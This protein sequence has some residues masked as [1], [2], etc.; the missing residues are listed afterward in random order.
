[1][2]TLDDID[3]FETLEYIKRTAP[4]Y[5]KAKADRIF[6]EEF[7]KS[8][9]ASLMATQVG[10]PVNAQERYAYAHPDYTLHLENMQT[11][12]QQEE[13][14]R[15]KLVAAQAVVEVW[16]SLSANQRAEAKAL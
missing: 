1:V 15:W 5:A 11:A 4:K 6:M 2:K 7:R 9:K 8:L 16:R 13:E 14:Y 12:I 10:D 3:I